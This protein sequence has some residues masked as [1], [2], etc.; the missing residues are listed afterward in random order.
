MNV[1]HY[2]YLLI[3]KYIRTLVLTYRVTGEC[4]FRNITTRK[5]Y[6]HNYDLF[7]NKETFQ[8]GFINFL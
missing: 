3:D 2:N 5:T 1:H 8:S 4:N 6:N 7:L